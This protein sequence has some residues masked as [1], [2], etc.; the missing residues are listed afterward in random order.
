MT[1]ITGTG[2]NGATNIFN[3]ESLQAL[4]AGSLTASTATA[5]TISD[6]D[7]QVSGQ[8][9][10]ITYSGGHPSGGTLT[11]LNV[12]VFGVASTWTGFSVSVSSLWQAVSS[13]NVTS[14]NALLFGGD[15]TFNASASGSGDNIGGYGGDDV[16]NYAGNF[17]MQNHL[18]GG[19]GSDTLKLNGDYAGDG[20]TFVDMQLISVENI[21]LGT[22]HDYVLN[23]RSGV[24]AS[25]ETMTVDATA[26]NAGDTLV[27]N[28]SNSD[29]GSGTKGALVLSGGAGDDV[30]YDGGGNDRY[31]G[32][33]GSDTVVF[34]TGSKIAIDLSLT[35]SQ[36][37]GAFFGHDVLTSVENVVTGSANDKITGN[38]DANFIDAGSGNN[39]IDGGD[40]N[41]TVSY[42]GT[43]GGII[44]LSRGKASHGDGR[45][46]L[47][48]IENVI[49]S[50]N[51]DQFLGT[52]GDNRIDG[53]GGLDAVDYGNAAG[54]VLFNFSTGGIGRTAG[55]AGHDTLIGISTVKGSDFN[56]RLIP[57]LDP[58]SLSGILAPH[59]FDGG[60]G[61]DTIDF[62]RLDRAVTASP[63]DSLSFLNVEN[64]IGT[65]FDDQMETEWVSEGSRSTVWGGAGDDTLRGHDRGFLKGEDGD[66][67]LIYS[68]FVASDWADGGAGEDTLSLNYFGESGEMILTA[69][70][71]RN[72]E[73][74][75]LSGTD[76]LGL[77]MDDAN[78][79][80][81]ATVDVLYEQPQPA[82][83]DDAWVI[84]DASAESTGGY[85]VTTRGGND[86]ITGGAGN[87]ILMSGAGEDM[88]DM[89]FGGRDVVAAGSGRDTIVAGRALKANDAI[90]GGTGD[91]TVNLDGVYAKG[92]TF[93][94]T[95]LVSVENIAVADG[96][97]YKL[98]TID[99]NVADGATLTADADHLRHTGRLVFDGSAETDGRFVLIGG[100]HADMLIG[101]AGDDQIEGRGGPDRL[102]GNG[103]VDTFVYGPTT[104]S[105]GANYDTI[106]GFDFAV[107]RIDVPSAPVAIDDS[108]VTGRLAVSKFDIKMAAAIDSIHLAAHHAVLFTPDAGTLAG[109][110]FVIVDQNG[111]AGYQAGSDFVLHLS[112]ATNTESVSVSVF[113]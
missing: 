21:V 16:F 77:K 113:V 54:G 99:A 87:D 72:V 71:I 59:S 91:D 29:G 82:F 51:N 27:L 26:L 11:S 74:I 95:T 36:N 40:G 47:T 15:D 73:H 12:N 45:D 19:D 106:V 5:F 101:G 89:S 110:L 42:A 30:F 80:G 107:D 94:A 102:I 55:G 2:S 53:G 86:E 105:T 34:Y 68:S 60:D 18:D 62:S 76:T 17:S 32:G 25:G 35:T 84:F 88:L 108:V 63:E 23:L 90:D 81:H 48:S 14:F 96:H 109:E 85:R 7:F 83:L 41:D 92:L 64:F 79:L 112:G 78:L 67:S 22:G 65:R 69:N 20:L 31:D 50:G 66:D 1:V 28:A 4:A 75:K 39:I 93:G 9:T 6:P 58:R 43:S 100:A 33:D 38:A 56:D 52:S 103:G 111:L 37:F 24:V 70:S 3:T 8:G 13:G 104:D 57:G 10:G 61:I 97:S 44:N 98:T 49:G 46:I